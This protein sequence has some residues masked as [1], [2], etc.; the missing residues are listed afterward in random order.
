M[1]NTHVKAVTGVTMGEA[2]VYVNNLKLETRDEAEAWV[3]IKLALF[4]YKRT[5]DFQQSLVDNLDRLVKAEK[6][7]A[8]APEE[9]RKVIKESIDGFSNALKNLNKCVKLLGGHCRLE[10]PNK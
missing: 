6:D 3:M 9:A 7:I 1:T 2:T 4:E 8:D 10:Q 5:E